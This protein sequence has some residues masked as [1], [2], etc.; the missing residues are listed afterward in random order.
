[1][2][3]LI[4]TI[5]L[6]TAP[7]AAGAQVEAEERRRVAPEAVYKVAP[8]L[9]TYTD[10]VLFGDVWIDPALEPRD[11]SL[12]TVSALIATGRTAQVGSHIGRALD[13]GVT[14]EE[15]A[16]IIAHLAF[17]T[18]WPNTI[19]SVFEIEQVFDARGITV[20]IAPADRLQ[21]EAEAE[22][23]R[24][25]SVARNVAPVA[26]KLAS[27][28]DE[29]LFADL[30]LRPGLVPRDRSLVTVAALIAMGQAEQLGFHLNRAL[31]NGLTPE[32]SGEALRH[33]AYYVGWPRAMSAV[34]VV[35]AT[36]EARAAA[37]EP[38]A[39]APISIVRGA[40]ASRADG[41]AEWFSGAVKIGPGFQASDPARLGGALVTFEAGART[42][43]H[44]HP[45]G[46]TL[47]VTAGRVWTQRDGDAPRSAGPGDIIQIPPNVRHWHGASD[48]EAGSH[49]AI[50]EA[51][52]GS[53][54][55]WMEPVSDA[56]YA[57][58]AAILGARPMD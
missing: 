40:E 11:R 37:A 19:S 16:E 35:R 33:I 17:Y 12:V 58:A 36:L 49:F 24:A 53:A 45:L 38:A 8:P 30:W 28:T 4:T 52:D 57:E 29:V 48:T 15:I 13:N 20:E 55:T 47:Y 44:T 3:N 43:W 9:G 6:T 10:A 14:P 41:P 39:E 21:P 25:A 46:Q 54:V 1:M 34:P 7:L 42:A 23:T 22:A 18:G 31:D 56:Q 32:Q 50:A 51:L 5:A 2:K 26:P 27:D